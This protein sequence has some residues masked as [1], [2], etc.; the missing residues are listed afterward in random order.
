MSRQNNVVIMSKFCRTTETTEMMSTMM[1]TMMTMDTKMIANSMKRQKEPNKWTMLKNR[2]MWQTSAKKSQK[3][4][5][6]GLSKRVAVTLP[7]PLPRSK[8]SQ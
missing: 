4:M 6:N 1:T 2:K 3:E 7:R 8:A 5:D